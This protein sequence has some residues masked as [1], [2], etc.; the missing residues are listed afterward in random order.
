MC[1]LENLP[2]CWTT[3]SCMRKCTSKLFLKLSFSAEQDPW[4]DVRS[5]STYEF[6]SGSFILH[7]RGPLSLAKYF[8]S[9]SRVPLPFYLTLYL[10]RRDLTPLPGLGGGGGPQKAFPHPPFG[11]C[12]VRS[13]RGFDICTV[14]TQ[15]AS[16]GR[17]RFVI[18]ARGR[19]W[20]E[21]CLSRKIIFGTFWRVSF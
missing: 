11:R 13:F 19:R 7:E 17:R 6:F 21:M 1:F 16:R 12:H 20:E 15:I 9:S 4:D 2:I 14:S 5:P 3:Q 10:P 18:K 8:P